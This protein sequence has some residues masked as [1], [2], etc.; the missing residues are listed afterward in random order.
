MNT[1]ENELNPLQSLQLI[2]EVITKTKENFRGYSFLYLLWG[3]L[4]AIASFAFFILHQYTSFDLFFLPFPVLAGCGILITVLHYRS[5]RHDTETWLS[6]Y[7]KNL[8]LVLGISFI[9]VVF[10]NIVQQRPPFTYT[11]LIGGVGTLISGM[12]LRFRPL[13][14]GGIIFFLFA[15]LSGLFITGRY[16]PLLQ[17]VAVVTGY[18]IPGYLLRRSPTNQA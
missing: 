11:L 15:L 7:L 17:G 18:L 5:K 10:I 3:W 6:G 13:I 9:L 12:S 8:W 14:F 4:I 2:T 1:Y 16:Q